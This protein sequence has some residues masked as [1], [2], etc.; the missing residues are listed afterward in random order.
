MT[1]DS[2]RDGGVRGDGSAG[3]AVPDGAARAVVRSAASKVPQIT[4]FFWIVKVLTTAMGE[5][6]SDYLDHRFAPPLAAAMA[7]LALVAALV[8]QFRARRYLA[9]AYWLVVAMVGVFG[10]MAADGLHVELGLPYAVSSAFYAVVL[11]VVFIVWYRVEGTLSIHSIR[12]P[13]R[14]GFYWATVLA[15]FA[16]GTALGDLTATTLHWGYLS[17]GVMFA[18]L[19][20]V[21]AVA[22]RWAGLSP[23]FAFWFAYIVTR[24]LGASFADWADVPRNRGGLNLGTGPVAL[25]LAA[26][27]VGFV[28]Y[29]A[30][31]RVDTDA[32]ADAV[33]GRAD[34]SP[35]AL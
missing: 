19:I 27:I 31:S 21:P 4:V 20:A 7:G 17:S 10:T 28:A 2:M 8:V 29:L 23:I 35:A 32:A 5:A 6:A 14:E 18:V 9:W 33:D 16:L 12:T 25:V 30:V 11:A 26:V 13:R 22:H 3:A 24:P 1:M 34:A 15:T